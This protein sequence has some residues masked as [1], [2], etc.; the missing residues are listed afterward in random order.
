M[1]SFIRSLLVLFLSI[2]CYQ[3]YAQ[4]CFDAGFESGT[5]NGYKTYLGTIDEF[6]EIEF[7][8]E[9]FDDERFAITNQVQSIDPIAAV[10]CL[11][12]FQ[13]S[14]IAPSGGRHSLRLGNAEGGAEA[15]KLVLEFEVTAETNFFALQYAVLL[16]DPNHE[17][18]E[19][20]RF[21]LRI[22]DEFDQT[23]PCG[24]Y[25]VSAGPDIPDFENCGEWRVRPW[26]TAGFELQSY[27][28]QTIKIEIITNDCSRGAHAGY[29]YIDATCKPLDIKLTGYCP[30][31]TEA[32]LSVTEGFENY[33]WNTG[34][35]GNVI[36]VND[37]MP[38]EIYSVDVTSANGCTITLTDTLPEFMILPRPEFNPLRDTTICKGNRVEINLSG[39]NLGD[40]YCEELDYYSDSYLVK[41]NE[42]T[43]YH[44]IT[45]DDYGCS[46]DTVSMKVTVVD[47]F[48]EFYGDRY[49]CM[50]DSITIG[51]YFPYED[52][53]YTW[54]TLGHTGTS[55]TGLFTEDV[56]L[57][58]NADHNG[59][60]YDTDLS[61][62]LRNPQP[63]AYSVSPNQDTSICQG[64]DII[65][66]VSSD[67]SVKIE[68]DDG[69][70]GPSHL[71]SPQE[72]MIMSAHIK[73]EFGCDSSMVFF[74]IDVVSS[75]QAQMGYTICTDTVVELDVKQKDV[76][77]EW[78]NGSKN[79]K[80]E[81]IE[82]GE[83]QVTISNQCGEVIDFAKVIFIAEDCPTYVPNVFSPN[84]D[85]I[86]DAFKPHFG[87]DPSLANEFLFSVY[88][89]WGNLVYQ[90]DDSQADAWDGY[91]NGTGIYTWHLKVYDQQCEIEK[92][93]TGEIL[94][95]R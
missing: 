15:E 24:E 1:I 91:Q 11:V 87:C 46:F 27:L 12:G 63:F 22:K 9:S 61:L 42:S 31:S 16:E 70:F 4:N 37:P 49:F 38:G 50:G 68:W 60:S 3:V 34:E 29:A 40:I 32:K 26:T 23:F 92:N 20:P 52:A 33:L 30:D 43:E 77:Y 72:D 80:I 2:V 14:P 64:E 66:T 67:N 88:D 81:A 17:E 56:T 93:E 36:T 55:Y 53:I 74:N 57:R 69:A 84:D 47:A 8:N 86:N 5:T 44:F 90:I 48:L 21:E 89:R 18:F 13:L 83:Y 62:V 54:D 41:P 65:F 76:N 10:N 82:S 51:I 58:I 78:S 75:P 95:V 59:C 35:T 85:F 39:N 6:G 45:Y 71:V 19:Q 7:Q 73:D 28:G 79:E 94:L 25:R